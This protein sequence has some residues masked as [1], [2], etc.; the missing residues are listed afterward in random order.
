MK[1]MKAGI[2]VDDANLFYVQKRLGWRIDFAKL[3]KLLG[4]EVD[5]ILTHYHIAVPAKWDQAFWQTE[6][7]L[8]N[9]GKN[10]E[11]KT[12]PL[13]YIRSG[14]FLIKKGDVDL[15]LALDVVRNLENLDLVIVLS[16]DSDYVELRKFVLEKGK[17]IVFLA[18]KENL[19]WEIKEGKYLILNNLKDY[20]Q[21]G[22][23]KTPRSYPGRLL[24]PILYQNEKRKSRGLD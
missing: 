6:K 23:K 9:I 3:F 13:K 21:F 15:E 12:K 24:L 19:S 7:Y 1:R 2:F 18:F 8:E 14:G 22:K 17:G 5:I 11:I 4:K 10:L 20:I 16:G